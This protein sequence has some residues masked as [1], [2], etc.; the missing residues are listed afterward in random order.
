MVI[1][2]AIKVL[3]VKQKALSLKTIANTSKTHPMGGTVRENIELI[4][5][6]LTDSVPQIQF[7]T[8]LS[9]RLDDIKQELDDK[10]PVIAWINIAPSVLD[11]VM[12]AVVITD[13]DPVNFEIKYIDP[14]MTEEHHTMKVSIGKFLDEKLGVEGRIIKLNISSIGQKDLIGGV[15]P[16]S[17]RKENE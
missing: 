3:G 11:T 10:R 7:Q 4:N 6:L 17:R 2:Y 13:Y 9:A 1:D 5:T 12:H 15:K 16:Y 8:L 14:E